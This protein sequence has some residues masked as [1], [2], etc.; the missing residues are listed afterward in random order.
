MEFSPQDA[1]VVQ[2]ALVEA[3]GLLAPLEAYHYHNPAH[4]RD[5]FGRSQR[6]CRRAG[7]EGEEAAEVAVA[8]AFHDA[9]FLDRYTD[10]EADGARRA[11]AWLAGR[12]PEDRVRRVEGMILATN[13]RAT[14]QTIQEKL[15]RDADLDNLG[16]GD[17]LTLAQA[18]RNELAKFGGHAPSDDDWDAGLRRLIGT[19]RWWTH[20]AEQDR[21]AGLE[22]N[23]KKAGVE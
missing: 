5:V 23:R 18:V 11:R 14:P 6:L 16:R 13:L 22:E 2:D 19:H 15:L 7:I 21:Q 17:F 4:T 10:N 20:A 9:G 3:M 12:W 8:A 1:R